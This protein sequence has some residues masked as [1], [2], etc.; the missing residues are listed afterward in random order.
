[1]HAVVHARTHAHTS[2]L[3]PPQAVDADTRLRCYFPDDSRERGL[4]FACTGAVARMDEPLGALGGGGGDLRARMGRRCA[5]L[6][7][8]PP[9]A[10][11]PHQP[12]SAELQATTSNRGDATLKAVLLQGGQAGKELVQ[13]MQQQAQ[14][15]GGGRV[16]SLHRPAP[17]HAPA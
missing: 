7:S 1:M 14:V 9:S 6:P 11:P 15:G 16:S 2:P 3:L 8:C 5:H 12:P 17:L 4:L 10:P 13:K